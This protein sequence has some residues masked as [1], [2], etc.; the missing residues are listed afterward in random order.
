MSLDSIL[1]KLKSL[2]GM[3]E[4]AAP[5]V[6]YTVREFLTNT[7]A[8]GT[9]AEGKQWKPTLEGERPLKTAAAHLKVTSIGPRI[10]VALTGHVARHNNGTAKGRIQRK[11]LPSK[12]LPS[13]MSKK[14]EETLYEVFQDLI[15][16]E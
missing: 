9:T 7:I 14:I 1:A 3:P 6:A 11:I 5:E 12:T 4:K 13:K 10:F 8:E 2:E 15:T 16:K